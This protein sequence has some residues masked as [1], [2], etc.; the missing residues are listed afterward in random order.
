MIEGAAVFLIVTVAAL[1]LARTLVRA[2]AG[3]GGCCAKGCGSCSSEACRALR[4][5]VRA[6]KV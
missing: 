6:R 5:R 3:K 2:V 1:Y 4:A